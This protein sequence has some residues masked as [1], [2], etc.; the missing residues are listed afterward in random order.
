MTWPSSPRLCHLSKV[1]S[2]CWICGIMKS[3]EAKRKLMS[4]L[5]CSA[6][7][8]PAN[9]LSAFHSVETRATTSIDVLVLVDDVEEAV[10]ALDG[11]HVA[12][13][14]DHDAGLVLAAEA[15]GLVD[16]ELHGVLRD[17]AVVGLDRDR[18]GV[19]LGRRPV[20]VDHRDAWP[21]WPRGS[22]GSRPC[23]SVWM[24]RIPSTLRAIIALTCSNCL[25]SSKFEMFS[26]TVQPFCLG[27]LAHDVEAGDPER[28]DQAVEQEGH[29]LALLRLG[30]H[31][32]A[33]GPGRQQRADGE[34]TPVHPH[35]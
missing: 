25:L 30:E 20:E 35:P 18:V 17:L 8:R 28:R 27:L 6:L 14:A 19:V 29:G 4:G 33:Q 32:Q 7:V 11:V 26:S 3:D 9:A 1:S 34:R 10:A 2:T 5:A 22:P 23:E 12:E 15:L 21:R 13:V 16:Q 31:R 24:I